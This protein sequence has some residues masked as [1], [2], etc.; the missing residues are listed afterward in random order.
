MHQQVLWLHLI[1]PVQKGNIKSQVGLVMIKRV[2]WIV[3]P[4]HFGCTIVYVTGNG[5]EQ[6]LIHLFSIY[7]LFCL[8]SLI[9]PH[10]YVGPHFLEQNVIFHVYVYRFL[11]PA[12]SVS[13]YPHSTYV[14]TLFSLTFC[15]SSWSVFVTAPSSILSKI[16]KFWFQKPKCFCNYH[17]LQQHVL[18][19]TGSQN[20]QP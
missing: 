1:K 19:A 4:S 13:K 15:S 9:I 18:K 12:I 7:I 17:L 5:L 14:Y 2:F 6:W 16:S 8:R 3:L 11:L 10:D 20:I